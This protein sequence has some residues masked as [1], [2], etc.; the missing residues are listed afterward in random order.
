MK[1]KEMLAMAMY[2]E[3]PKGAASKPMTLA[4]AKAIFK[5]GAEPR[6]AGGA[7]PAQRA[8]ADGGNIHGISADGI[9]LERKARAVVLAK[10]PEAMRAAMQSKPTTKAVDPF[11]GAERAPTRQASDGGGG[12]RGRP[13]HGGVAV[14]GGGAKRR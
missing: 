11:A 5:D 7:T 10:T 4:Q 6:Q 14:V 12:S 8:R 3:T 1:P 2:R 9:A 13:G